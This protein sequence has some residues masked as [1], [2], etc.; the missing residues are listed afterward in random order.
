MA[1]S[2]PPAGGN[3]AM[4]MGPMAGDFM[5]MHEG[6]VENKVRR[7]KEK[8]RRLSKNSK[9]HKRNVKTK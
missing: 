8:H 4:H 5:Q 2:L 1:A 6:E 3:E 9:K 7:L